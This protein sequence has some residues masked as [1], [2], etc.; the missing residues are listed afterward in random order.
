MPISE[1]A[2]YY[3]KTKK[4]WRKWLEKNHTQQDAI[5]L[6]MYKKNAGQPT[7]TWSDAVDE[8]LCFG[9]IDSIKK[10]L[11]EER[12]IQFFSK[13]KPKSTWSRINKDKVQ[14]LMDAGL[15][16]KA[17]L[18]CITIA[19]ENGSWTILDSVEAL[20]I[21]EDLEAALKAKPKAMD[22]FLSLSKS[23]KKILLHR[24]LFAKRPETRGKRMD[25]ILEAVSAIQ[26][27]KRFS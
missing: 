15:M 27:P 2:Q 14:Q 25:E 10:K 9:W 13:R 11:D 24:L 4:E 22:N 17:G 21:P 3:P 12:S 5:W 18:N 23:A 26:Q 1:I 19:K 16:T 7:I 6:I 20:I 8:A